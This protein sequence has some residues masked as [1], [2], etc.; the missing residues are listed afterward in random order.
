MHMKAGLLL[1][2]GASVA[3]VAANS[4]GPVAVKKPSP[5]ASQAT[6]APVAAAA[7]S[8]APAASSAIASSVARWHSLRQSDNLPFSSYASFLLGHRGWPGEAAMRRSAERQVD[9]ASASPNEVIR[10]FEA[11]PPLTPAGHARY[12]FALQ[13]VGR[14]EQA[15][16]AARSAWLAG[17]LP[18]A[19][20]QR[21][22]GA[23]ASSFTPQDHDSRMEVLLGHG[24]TQSAQRTLAWASAAK[25]P[26]Y[27]ARLALQTRASD[28]RSRVDALGN[29]HEGDPGLLIDK[30][31]WLRSSD[32][33]GARQ[34]LAR[35]RRLASR[36][37]APEKFM[38]S[39]VVIT[40]GAVADRQWTLA[41]QIASQ[42]DDIFAP[43]TDISGLSYGERDE[44]TNL[45]WL[46]GQAALRLARPA[47]AV[48]MFERY[49]RAAR[50]GQTRSKGYYWAARSA[51]AAGQ[52][53]QSSRLLEETAAYPDQF[54]G[55]L[56]LERL[57]RSVPAPAAVAA[58]TAAERAAFSARP[59]VQAAHYLGES[60]RWSDQSLFVR[61]IAEQAEGERER[62]I[63]AEYGRSIGR[64]DLGVWV[65]R[66]AR[67][68]GENLYA[69]PAFPE[70]SL[71][72]AYAHN[73]SLAH[74]ITRQES[75]FDRAAVSHA[76]A[77]GLMQLMPG[78]AR[79]TAGRLG[80]PYDFGRLTSDPAYN[81]MLGS[82]YFDTLLRQWGGNVPLAV[83]SYNAGAGNVRRWIRENGDPRSGGVDMVEWIEQ[84]P[85]FETRNYVQRVI[86][87]AVVYDAIRARRGGG[88][89]NRPSVY[90]RS[91]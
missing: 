71:P 15:R 11:F 72:G 67:N 24:D 6:L 83:A 68:K 74:G 32:A 46:A 38:E 90:L 65:A 21:L 54:Y 12:A 41:Y 9:P 5:V 4:V 42:V 43:G 59:L 51:H 79:E 61:A 52:A 1:L 63:A 16:S 87:N 7:Q 39:M 44:Y 62:V 30:A 58:S 40:R 28:A 29:A 26:L 2:L 20:E 50:S 49:A 53:Q 27:E 36:P 35:P 80:I 47:D 56:A 66:E 86:E 91:R 76:G 77:R 70:V 75:S 45:T 33:A 89:A 10:F 48:G 73:W 37:A 31:N 22:L 81:I 14:S 78:T 82:S 34:L 18:A 23:F 19:D 85:F 60:G 88:S 25:R 84:I 64:L 13:A 3:A 57:G 55:Q 69:A 17:V 8:A